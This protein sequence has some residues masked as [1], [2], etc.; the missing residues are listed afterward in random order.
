MLGTMRAL[1]KTAP[2]EGEGFNIQEMIL[3]HL[4]DSHEWEFAGRTFHLPTFEPVH[5]GPLTLDFSITKHVLFM[6][7][8]AVLVAAVLIP[9]ARK[10]RRAHAEGA[11]RGPKGGANV[12]EAF[13]LY[14]RD[15]VAK[16][17]VGH[18]G[19]R[20]YPY[21]IAVFFF[22]LFC[23]LLGLIP[24]GAS[25][26]GNIS[27]TA[28]LAAVTFFVVEIAGM[29]ELGAAGY[30]KTIFYAPP[31]IGG[32]GKFLM[33]LIMTPVEFLGKLTKPFA[34]AIRLYANMTAG[35]A[36]VLA[37]TG[38]LVLAAGANALWVAPAPLLMAIAIMLLEIFVAFLQAYIFAMLTA[39]FIGLIRHAH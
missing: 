18:H 17:N 26:T 21:V 1:M 15:E 8:A 14:L 39:V 25:P 12:V 24:W 5:W 13:I 38:L 33:L 6:I 20:Y 31:G 37:L 36:V 29:R 34:L 30:S 7:V 4:A 11:A 10:A 9:A 28:A 23:N 19:E 35:H 32:A 3:H 22:I 2:E 16:P 27:V